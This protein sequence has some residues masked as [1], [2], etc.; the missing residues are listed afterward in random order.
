MSIRGILG[1]RMRFEVIA[2]RHANSIRFKIDE[3][4]HSELP[5]FFAFAK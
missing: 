4:S 5:S 1:P 3:V 2:I